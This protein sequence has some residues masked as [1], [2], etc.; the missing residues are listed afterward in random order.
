MRSYFGWFVAKA[1]SVTWR[2]ICAP[3]STCRSRKVKCDEAKPVC[4][5]CVK[6]S[7]KCV[8]PESAAFRNSKPDRHSQSPRGPRTR[9][10]NPQHTWVDVPADLTFVHVTTPCDPKVIEGSKEHSR[11]SAQPLEEDVVLGANHDEPTESTTSAGA[12]STPPQPQES[13]QLSS[14]SSYTHFS[15]FSDL[16]GEYGLDMLNGFGSRASDATS[17]LRD[18][19]PYTSAPLDQVHGQRDECDTNH[20]VLEL[21]LLKHFRDGPGQW[22]DLFDTSAYFSRKVPVLASTS[23]MLRCS[24]CAVAAKH[25]QRKHHLAVNL[26]LSSYQITP[27]PSDRQEENW[28]YVSAKY[29]QKAIIN[30]KT[31]VDSLALDDDLD[32][33]SSPPDEIFAVIAVLCMYESMDAPGTA[34]K[35]HLSALPL[36]TSNDNTEEDRRYKVRIPRTAIKSPVFW[37]LARQDIL[38]AFISESQT[39][40]KVEDLMFWHNAGLTTDEICF[41]LPL[42]PGL[43]PDDNNS[44]AVQEDIKAKQLICIL[45]KAIN[46]ITSGDALDPKDFARPPGQRLLVGVAQEQLLECWNAIVSELRQW[47]EALPVTFAPSVRT[48]RAR[49]TALSSG[50]KNQDFQQIWYDIPA[51]AA[52]MQYYHMACIL[53]LVNRPQE[54]TAIRSTVSARLQSYRHDEQRA[55]YHAREICGISNA[56]PAEPFRIHSVQ[57]LF[58]AGQVFHESEDHCMVTELLLGIERDLG[59]STASYI[60]KL[61]DEWYAVRG[62]DTA[63]ML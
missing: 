8:F 40:L 2:L 5:S 55:L 43:F 16:T 22:M 31:A 3:S 27:T 37:S 6:A 41:Q 51:C 47:Y 17:L 49:N 44:S 12:W 35:A 1:C 34:W 54:S 9:R 4:G 60:A 29:Y 33:S 23:N 15:S 7:R 50:Q 61:G 63:T 59:W 10:S 28:E 62:F 46:F 42:T 36:F 25:I 13:S 30:L 11:A 21:R 38:C 52:T 14:P 56:E 57:P 20:H 39:R 32:R 45:G 19:A 58:V 48:R 26:P 18:D 24:L 53:L